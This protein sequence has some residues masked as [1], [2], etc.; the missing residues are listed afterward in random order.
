MSKTVSSQEHLGPST[1]REDSLQEGKITYLYNYS[2][3]NLAVKTLQCQQQGQ[4]KKRM[5][6]ERSNMRFTGRPPE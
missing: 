4:R 5:H 6:T 2:P 1:L 3:K